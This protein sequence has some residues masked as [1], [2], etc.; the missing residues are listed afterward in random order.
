[1]WAV[2]VDTYEP[3]GMGT[4]HPILRHIFYGRTQEEAVGYY[5][6]HR[7][8][9]AFLRRCVDQQNWSGIYCPSKIRIVKE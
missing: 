9:D 7:K 4:A 3:E 8:T 6:A 5:R 2:I 1:M